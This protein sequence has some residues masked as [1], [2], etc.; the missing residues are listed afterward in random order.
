MTWIKKGLVYKADGKFGWDASHS[1]V[2]TAIL[3]SETGFL[4]I[5]YSSRNIQNQSQISFVDVNPADPSQVVYVHPDPIL[6]PGQPG[7]FDDCGV[8]PSWVVYNGDRLYLYYIGWNVRNTVP[9]YNSV[10]LAVS[11]DGSHFELFSTGPLWDRDD[12]EPFFSASTCVL[13][14]KNIWKNWYL[15]CT[16]YRNVNGLIEPRY[17]IKYA[18][19]ANGIDWMRNGVIAI[20]YKSDEEAGIVRASVICDPEIFRMWFSYRNFN[21]YRTDRN[22]SYKIGYAESNDGIV[23]N[24]QDDLA[25]I[26]LSND[27]WDSQMQAYPNV[28]DFQNT[29][30][31]F[32]NGNEFGKSGFGFAVYK[33]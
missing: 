27:G 33:K 29:R 10:G 13:L 17:H 30:Y 20:D 26:Y 19:S 23:W 31:M 2:P 7:T 28:I 5:Y 14:H 25:G 4:R 18:E 6:L 32:Y 11:T 16:E 3:L 12:K 1:Q 15:S 24:R 8:M 22:N 9:Y 21:N